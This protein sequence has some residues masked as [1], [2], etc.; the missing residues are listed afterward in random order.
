MKILANAMVVIILQYINVPKQHP[1]LHN[2]IYQL[3][4]NKAGEK[5]KWTH[6]CLLQSMPP[7]HKEKKQESTPEYQDF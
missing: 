1:K 6:N 2:V 7:F 5:K 3:Y 4:L